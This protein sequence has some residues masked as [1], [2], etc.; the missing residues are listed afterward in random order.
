V[1]GLDDASYLLLHEIRLR[2]V[3]AVGD[4]PLAADLVARG[5]VV[6]STRG[7][8]VTPEGRGLHASWARLVEGSDDEEAVQRAYTRFL[9]LNR[10]LIRIC[11]DWQQKP[12]DWMVLDRAHALDERVGPL[13]NAVGKRIVRFA[14]YRVQLREA[15]ARVDE[16]AHEWMTSPRCDSYHTVW[17]RFHEDLL[18]ALGAE[19]SSEQEPSS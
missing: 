17:M 13:V 18:L 11:H 9:P 5:Y 4:D 3:V 12:G 8:R 7:A 2:G 15:I 16:G 1:A 14:S 19:R 10:E 6:A